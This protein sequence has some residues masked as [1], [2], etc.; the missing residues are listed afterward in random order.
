MSKIK[1]VKEF[2]E[3]YYDLVKEYAAMPDVPEDML[4]D[5][6]DADEEWRHWKIIP[7][8]ITENDFTELEN[9][10]S[11]TFSDS[12][13][14]FYSSYFHLFDAPIGRHSSEEPFEGLKN[15]WNPILAKNEYLPFTWDNDQYMIRCIDLKNMPNEDKCAVCEI[16]HEILFDLDESASREDIEKH[17]SICAENFIDYLNKCYDE[18]ARRFNK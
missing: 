18:M 10:M 15:A 14:Q 16:S 17:M 6:S 11:I 9:T 3:K 2:F 7:A 12:M 4:L 5:D 13:K 1:N 8:T